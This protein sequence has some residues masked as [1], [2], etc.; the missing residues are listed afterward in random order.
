[1]LPNCRVFNFGQVLGYEAH[2][3]PSK[4]HIQDICIQLQRMKTTVENNS[5]RQRITSQYKT[6][7]LDK[8]LPRVS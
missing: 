5:V 7:F 1:M 6:Q 4:L 3:D 2:K 8:I